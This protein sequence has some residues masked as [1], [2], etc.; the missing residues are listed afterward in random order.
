M[1]PDKPEG[2]ARVIQDN[3]VFE[4]WVH[5]LRIGVYGSE[6]DATLTCKTLNHALLPLT[7]KAHAAEG[8]AEAL[9]QYTDSTFVEDWGFQKEGD[10][11]E[12]ARKALSAYEEATK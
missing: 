1:T 7:K 9:R 11:G 2:P 3:D 8:M 6:A 5:F 4:I 10:A 12:V